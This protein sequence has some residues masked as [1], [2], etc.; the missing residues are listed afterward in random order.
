[1]KQYGILTVT[2]AT[3]EPVT[4]AE[5]ATSLRIDQTADENDL[6]SSLIV[7]ARRRIESQ[8]GIVCGQATFDQYLD[9]YPDRY[10][11]RLQRWPIQSVTHFKYLDSSGTLTT[12]A[13]TEYSSKLVMNPARIMPAYGVSWPTLRGVAEQIQIRFIAGY[14]TQ[15]AI[16]EPIK[17]AIKLL[18]GHWYENRENTTIATLL[19]IPYGVETLLQPYALN[20]NGYL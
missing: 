1:M 8:F 11:I 7:V 13:T 16:P 4:V 20:T 2:D 19:P 5:V 3:F 10:T 17:T 18:V 6:L 9:C 15:A 12:L 14:A